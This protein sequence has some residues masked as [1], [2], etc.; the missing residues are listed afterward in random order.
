MATSYAPVLLQLFDDLGAVLAGGTV[1]TFEA[2]TS[3]PLATYQDLDGLVA[4]ANPVVLDA[5][6]RAT[7]RLTDGVAYK[8][9]VKDSDGNLIQ[10]QDNVI[11]GEAATDTDNQ[12]LISL[13][14]VGTPGAQATMG[15]HAVTHSMTLPV[16]FDG[17]SGDVLTAPG[18]DYIISVKKNEVEVGTVTFDSDGVA[19][20][21][22]TSGASVSCAFGDVISFHGPAS[23]GT[24]V[25]I[26]VTLVGD[27]A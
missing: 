8:F 6:G 10:T 12:Y 4:N 13:T 9:V 17:A 25:D 16:N 22:T 11:V 14:Y 20:F 24:A 21:A 7:I 19:T 2:G 15:L 27:L 26:A 1:D 5:A 18:S 23:V 3:T